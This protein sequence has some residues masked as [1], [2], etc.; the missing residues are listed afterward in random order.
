MMKQ[1]EFNKK[2]KEIT[3]QRS[4]D[5]EHLAIL[6]MQLREEVNNL[7]GLVYR[8]NNVSKSASDALIHSCEEAVAKIMAI[9]ERVE[10]DV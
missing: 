5:K 4:L 8:Y 3:I 7:E 1:S 9:V 10:E 2:V 6:A